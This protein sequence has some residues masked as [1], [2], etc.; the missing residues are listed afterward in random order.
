MPGGEQD[1][2][3]LG[4]ADV[5]VAVRHRVLE[6]VQAGAGV[7]RGGD[8]AD[9]LV[10]LRLR[11]QRLA[12]H[13]GVLRRLGR[14]GAAAR[15]LLRRAGAPLDDRRGLGGMPLL[16]ALQAAVLGGR[17]ALALDRLAVDDDRA[18]GLERLADRL[19]QRADVV[20]VDHADV[21]QVELLEQQA[22]APRTP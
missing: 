5:V 20:A 1:G 14:L 21:G 17:E 13:R 10:A 4:D 19:A 7:H 6:Q 8:A 16:H 12:E 9:A 15:L 3:L 22:R 11:D 18:V 2:V